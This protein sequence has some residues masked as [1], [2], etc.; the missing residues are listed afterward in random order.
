MKAKYIQIHPQNPQE[1]KIEEVVEMLRNGAVIIYPTDTVY[2][3]GCDVHHQK[4][5]ERVCQI[6]NINPAKINLSFICDDLSH[7]SEYTRNLPTPIF[8]LMKKAL[9]GPF[10][11]ILPSGSKVP[12]MLNTKKNTIGIRIPNHNITRE[13][14]KALGNPLLSTSV[15]MDDEV[16][17]MTDPELMLEKYEKLVDIIIDGGIG[18]IVPST[19]VDCTED[20][21]VLIR[22][23]L[24][25]LAAFL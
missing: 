18:N 16:E 13:I 22:E 11:F 7:I 20:I 14:V 12:K 4:A 8:K 17:Y 19:I 21:P 9:P 24:G 3:I 5:V 10:T 23:G 6:K 2:G 15:P 25:N 1:N